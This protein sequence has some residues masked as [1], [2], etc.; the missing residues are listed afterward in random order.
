MTFLTE[1][2][3]VT[4]LV[5]AE[6]AKEKGRDLRDRYASARPFPHIAIDNFLPPALL[7]LCLADFPDSSQAEQTY[8]R[9]QER[10]KRSYSPDV[11]PTQT[12]QLFYAFNSRP[13]I[14]VIE[15]IS[16]IEGLIPDP[17]FLGGGL[18]EIAESGHLSMH[19]DFN[20]HVP[21]N[22]ERRINLLIYLNK[23]WT[24]DYGGQL[25]LWDDGMNRRIQSY[26]PL[27]N[28]CVIFST[29]SRSMHGN[30]NP[31]RHPR[32]MPRRSIALYYYTA[33][34]DATKRDHTTQFKMRPGTNDARDFQVRRR[35]LANDLIPPV[36]YR[37][38]RRVKNRMTSS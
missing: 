13:F 19:A 30:P 24:D 20:H 8:N 25:E 4:G 32:R 22:L 11:L 18:H 37:A 38:M 21:M 34:W 29:T 15:N 23:D 36:L 17:Y 31:V 6:A 3:A 33:T 5:D 2:D 28:R 16:G 12:R 14:K 35:E 1:I 7:E 10:L 27:F 9:D 26:V